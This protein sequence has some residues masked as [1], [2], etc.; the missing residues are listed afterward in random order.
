MEILVVVGTRPE[1]VKVAPV[2]RAAAADDAVDVTLVHTNQ[3]YDA[4]LSERFF[5]VLGLD[6][7]DENLEIGSG[8]HAEQTA[9]ALVAVDELLERHAPDVVVAQGDTNAVLSAAL[10]AS[11]R[12]SAFA[13]VEAGLRSF[14]RSMPEETNRVVA[15]HVT[16]LAFAPTEDAAARLRS[17]SVAADVFVTGNTVVDACLEHSTIAAEQSTVR[18]R[19]DLREESYGVATIHRPRNADDPERLREILRALDD[20]TDPV[21]FPAHPRTA[22]AIDDL[23]YDPSGSLRVVE[24]LDYLDFLDLLSNARVVVTDSG[25]VQEESSVL[26][27]PCLT[28][29]PNTERPET[30]DAGVNE[31]VTPAALQARLETLLSDDEK[32]QSMTGHPDLYGDGRSGE[33]IVSHVREWVDERADK[34]PSEEPAVPNR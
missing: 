9:S 6:A 15:D 1:L 31:L 5:E 8:S 4:S 34:E 21:V 3:H 22:A 24:P 26:E 20:Q 2:L 25:G 29:R 27:V 11:K 30:V 32:R 18:D 33:R 19:F 17:E 12:P 16:D 23:D 10:A 7:P 28:V 13:H 14:D